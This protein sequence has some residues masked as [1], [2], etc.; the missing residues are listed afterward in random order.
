MVLR[1]QDTIVMKPASSVLFMKKLLNMLLVLKKSQN[2]YLDTIFF[3]FNYY[4]ILKINYL[5]IIII[6]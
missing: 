3:H 4:L 5:I 2:L 1:I 6:K